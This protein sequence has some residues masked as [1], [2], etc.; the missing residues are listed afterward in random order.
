[1]VTTTHTVLKRYAN[2]FS[3]AELLIVITI[4]GILGSIAL[5][6][7]FNQVKKTRQNQAA[8][9]LSQIQTTIAAFVD[10]MGLLPTS[11]RDLNNITPLM[12]PDGPANQTNFEWIPLASNNCSKANKSNCYEIKATQENQI[13]TL[14][15]RAADQD[16]L[17][18][19][20]VACLDLRTGSSDLRKGS[21]SKETSVA[22]LRC[23]R[24]K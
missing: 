11:W 5:P 13:F 21:H 15:A 1:M 24:N 2:G 14:Q 3:L 12:T 19:N 6:Q 22:D 4:V 18:Y 17:T 16:A 8:A 20:V 23:V 9:S 10:E 7:Y